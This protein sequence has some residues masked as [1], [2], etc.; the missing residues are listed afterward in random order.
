MKCLFG[1]NYFLRKMVSASKL[2]IFILKNTPFIHNLQLRR[3][4]G[5]RYKGEIGRRSLQ[6]PGLIGVG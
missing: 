4:G 2:F 6:M 1:E 3:E 5:V